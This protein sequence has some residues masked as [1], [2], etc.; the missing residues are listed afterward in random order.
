L[1]LSVETAKESEDFS[2][3]AAKTRGSFSVAKFTESGHASPSLDTRDYKILRELQR[4]GRLKVV[5]LAER[6]S[7]SPSPCFA[8]LKRLEDEGY[9]KGYSAILDFEKL[10]KPVVTYVRVTLTRHTKQQFS[11][12]E[13]IVKDIPEIISCHL[14][15]A[16][17]DYILKMVSRDIDH[18]HMVTELLFTRADFISQH[19]TFITIKEVKDRSIIPIDLLI[20][21]V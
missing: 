10:V 6:I 4:D 8:R 1:T 16:E 18:F 9:I 21:E 19:F 3:I 7:L 2:A 11:E 17:F 14:V 20:E 5:E 13:K 12:F 15:S